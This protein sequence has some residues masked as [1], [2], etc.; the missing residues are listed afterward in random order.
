M[1]AVATEKD[2]EYFSTED[3]VVSIYLSNGYDLDETQWILDC[4]E[5]INRDSGRAWHLI[6]PSK[7]SA[8]DLNNSNLEEGEKKGHR[9]VVQNRINAKDYNVELAAN[10]I[11]KLQGTQSKKIFFPILVFENFTSG[12]HPLLIELGRLERREILGFLESVASEI[13]DL[14]DQVNGDPSNFRDQAQIRI[15]TLAN[16]DWAGRIAPRA[17]G[18]GATATGLLFGALSLISF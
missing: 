17:I 11:N 15:K 1:W 18:V 4:W 14:R 7:K 6:I 3:A 16:R 8:F 5:A 12:K 9:E 10:I 2:L 13:R